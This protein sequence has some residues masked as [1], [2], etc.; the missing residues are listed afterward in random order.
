MAEEA[1]IY[2]A[3]N[4]EAKASNDMDIYIKGE[5]KIHSYKETIDIDIE[6]INTSEKINQGYITQCRKIYDIIEPEFLKKTDTFPDDFIKKC[7]DNENETINIPIEVN[8]KNKA[9]G[10]GKRVI[11]TSRQDM[12]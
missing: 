6:N 9:N 10:Y 7:K 4:A 2:E 8:N 5:R 11:C 3:V 1:N 12:L